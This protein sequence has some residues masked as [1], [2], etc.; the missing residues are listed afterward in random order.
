MD[1]SEKMPFI[2]GYTDGFSYRITSGCAENYLELWGVPN[3]RDGDELA[4]TYGWRTSISIRS[5]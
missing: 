5:T 1:L 3:L 2:G 4:V